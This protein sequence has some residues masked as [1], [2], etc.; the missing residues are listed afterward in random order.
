MAVA[1]AEANSKLYEELETSEGKN[2]IYRIATSRNKVTKD[3]SHVKQME[4]ELY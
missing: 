3:I 4:M 1:R 2:K